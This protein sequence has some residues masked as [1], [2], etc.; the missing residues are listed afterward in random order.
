MKSWKSWE[1]ETQTSKLGKNMLFLTRA[2][3]RAVEDFVEANCVEL[4]KEK[5][6]CPLSGKKFKGKEFIQK[7][8]QSKHED[9][10]AEVRDEVCAQYIL[11]QLL[12]WL[13]VLRLVFKNVQ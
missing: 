7:H 12:S 8:L 5:W 10:L 4:A 2:N 3:F 6:L 1:D 13:K 9:K 11:V